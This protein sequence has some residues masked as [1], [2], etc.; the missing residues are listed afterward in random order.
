MN[1]S[2]SSQKKKRH[3]STWF[4][5]WI[6]LLAAIVPVAYAG[7]S[8]LYSNYLERS[9]PIIEVLEFPRGV[10]IAP[11]RARFRFV[12]HGAGLDEV[13]IRA[14]QKSLSRELVR[15]SLDGKKDAE[16]TI[17]LSGE[18]CNFDEGRGELEVRVF[19]RGFLSNTIEEKYQLEVDY[20]KPHIEVLSGQHNA[21]VGGSQLLIYKAYDENLAV[22]GVK[23]GTR[24]FLGSPAK[25]LDP[26]F[27]DPQV[28]AVIYAVENTVQGVA[29]DAT[30]V[31]AFAEDVV[32][33]AA[34]TSFYS[35]ISP[36]SPRRVSVTL[37]EGFLRQQAGL[38]FDN[39]TDRLQELLTQSGEKFEQLIGESRG[40]NLSDKF[41]AVNEQLRLLNEGEIERLLAIPR[42]ERIWKGTFLQQPASARIV[43]GDL[44]SYRFNDEEIG[45]HLSQG[46]YLVPGQKNMSV[47]AVSDGV[48]V[49]SDN[50]GVYGRTL[51]ID[52]GL[53]VFSIYG[54]LEN[55]LVGKGQGVKAG[56]TIAA[57]GTTGLARGR[58]LYF[59]LRVH[60][61]PVDPREWWDKQ[62]YQAHFTE[63]IEDVKRALG[64]TIY[65]GIE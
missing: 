39:N 18:K 6:C 12:D 51:A 41:R 58:E 55:V 54:Q 59:E 21:R 5:I 28:F 23:V 32:G 35:K 47:F 14:R 16:I 25:G 34:S 45:S 19:D 37:D 63:K 8:E 26:A 52:H 50:I 38:L 53:G 43:F 7:W 24:T 33:N 30:T 40:Y 31:R 56:D 15:Q 44:I 20:R 65:R 9:A 1:H 64:I 27:N 22:S 49:F 11:V 57:I 42:I 36:R 3:I 46:Y 48:V 2:E 4:V 13:V 29:S 17:E 61:V 62:W 10:G 60:G